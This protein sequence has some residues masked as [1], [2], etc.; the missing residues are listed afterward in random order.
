MTLQKPPRFG[1]H[2]VIIRVMVF[3]L[4]LATAALAGSQ[5]L[6]I[7]DDHRA[8]IFEISLLLLF[9]LITE[10]A[11]DSVCSFSRLRER[12]GERVN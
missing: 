10:G 9:E 2:P 11:T 1:P 3:A 5:F 8:E 6:Q 7:F 4:T 12:G